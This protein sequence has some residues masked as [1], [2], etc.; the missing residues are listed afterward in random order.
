[1]K[2]SFAKT[3]EC[4]S[5]KENPQDRIY[6]KETKVE[7]LFDNNPISPED[8]IV[9]D[10]E[11]AINND[12]KI[13]T[14]LAQKALKDQYDEIHKT[15]DLEKKNF[16]KKLKDISKSSDC[17]SEFISA[18]KHTE[19]DDFFSCL[20]SIS[21][22]IEKKHQLFS[23]KYNDIFDKKGNVRKFLDKN[24]ALIQEYFSVYNELLKQ[25]S[26]FNN[27][28]ETKS[29]FGTYQAKQIINSID[30]DA[31]F[32]A[33][34]KMVLRTSKEINSKSDLE[35]VFEGEINKILEDEKLKK[36]FRKI[37]EALD[38]NI[39]LR[40]FKTALTKDL[41]IL[42]HLQD[43]GTFR[44]VVW[45]G[46]ISSLSSDAKNLI[47]VYKDNYT[48][49]EQLLQQARKENETWEEIIKIYKQRFYVPFSIE[50]ENQE[51][52][53]LKQ[54][55]A[56]L[57]FSYLSR[58]GEKIK[59]ERQEIL[60]VLSKGERRAFFILQ[61][62]FELEARK[63][64]GKQALVIFDDISD[65]FDYKNKYAIIE[66]IRD[67][68]EVK[69][70]RQIILTH[71]FDFYRTIYSRLGLK[72]EN[73]FIAT[74]DENGNIA[75]S[76]GQYLKDFFKHMLTQKNPKFFI[77]I[78]PFVRNI[79][80]YTKGIESSE[81]KLLTSC[82]HIK[83]DSQNISVAEIFKICKETISKY[84]NSELEASSENIIL[85]IKK[86]AEKISAENSPSEISL[87]NK[88]VLSIGIR[89]LA[90]EYVIAN[91]KEKKDIKGHQTRELITRFKKEYPSEKD[92]LKILDR[93]NLMTP[94]NIHVN[95]FMYE[96]LIDMSNRHLLDLFREL[97]KLTKQNND[98]ESASA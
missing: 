63:N 27:G 51:D 80:E 78:L 91:M 75:L 81:Y 15:L 14:L 73:A 70:F 37:D 36:S 77:G 28:G 47:S 94:E 57:T 8:I 42:P 68:K 23:F 64:S 7:I 13:T 61:L 69:F 84:E 97:R 48:K 53:I 34:H 20:S 29:S 12:D 65:S 46:F 10:P 33:S 39:E 3:F 95:T 1:M 58:S 38:K 44:K 92:V 72:R 96:P 50:I 41:S 76:I 6:G 85:F 35:A 56:N 98:T 86:C 43:Y 60:N 67:L 59:K 79:I 16:L 19:K 22:E 45:L 40:D 24:K 4:L 83:E 71:N 2:S 93:V 62:L 55:T 17:E 88:F 89:L 52:I 54:E 30:G 5:K 32:N 11:S 90:E 66:Y 31:F 26:F 74:L 21:P 25:S 82:L 49:L 87:E 18:F 9:A